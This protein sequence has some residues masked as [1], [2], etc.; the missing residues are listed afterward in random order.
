MPHS[1]SARALLAIS[2]PSTVPLLVYQ[3]IGAWTFSILFAP[4]MFDTATVPPA[5]WTSR[6]L[7]AQPVPV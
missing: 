3:L 7:A 2:T 1:H 5:S 4:F 6:P